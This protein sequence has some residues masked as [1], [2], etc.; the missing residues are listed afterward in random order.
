MF[1]ANIMDGKFKI[2]SVEDLVSSSLDSKKTLKEKHFVET[3]YGVQCAE[4]FS[5]EGGSQEYIISGLD[6]GTV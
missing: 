3:P 2:F 5:L 1:G 4:H 6:D